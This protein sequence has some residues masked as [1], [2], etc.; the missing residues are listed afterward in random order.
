MSGLFRSIDAALRFAFAAELYP[1]M[2]RAELGQYTG[3]GGGALLSQR[4]WHAQAALIRAYVDRLPIAGREYVAAFYARGPQRAAAVGR[5]ARTLDDADQWPQS[6]ANVV[7]VLS[8]YCLDYPSIRALA[9]EMGL[10]HTTVMRVEN[11]IKATLSRL[12][13]E[14]E[15]SIHDDFIR[16][17]LVDPDC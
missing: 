16:R 12:F 2:P 3:R 10:H 1:V 5:M 9:A 17:G 6:R 13:S 14:T 11:K 15:Q 7:A 4:E 8:R